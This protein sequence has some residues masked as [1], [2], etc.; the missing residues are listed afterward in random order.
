MK[1]I[2]NCFTCEFGFDNDNYHENYNPIH[3]DV[4]EITCAC[5]GESY[6]KKV[7][8]DFYCKFWGPSF[9]EFVRGQKEI[10][11]NDFYK[12]RLKLLPK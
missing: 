9:S 3:P 4:L 6:G 10:S 7:K 1:Y 11:Y 2:E 5:S 12:E 8:H